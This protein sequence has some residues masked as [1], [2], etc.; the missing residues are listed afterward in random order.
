MHVNSLCST[1]TKAKPELTLWGE[2]KERREA[3]SPCGRPSWLEWEGDRRS[4]LDETHK[5]LIYT[6][7]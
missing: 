2:T 7:L 1:G 6:L 5:L 4:V 3:T